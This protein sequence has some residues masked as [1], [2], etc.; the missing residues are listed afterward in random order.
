MSDPVVRRVK[1]GDGTGLNVRV[2]GEGHPVVFLHEL[3]CG[4]CGFEPVIDLLERDWQCVSF[5]ARG[6]PPSDVPDL[7]GAYSQDAAGSDL[8]DVMDHC[9]LDTAHVVGVSMGASAALHAALTVPR[10]VRT[11]TLV[12]IGTGSTSTPEQHPVRSPL[13][14]A[15]A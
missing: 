4:S 14:P 5:D 1:A 11:L 2:R 13:S 6:F 3:L 10:R 8:F 12:S 7:P 15:S 9:G